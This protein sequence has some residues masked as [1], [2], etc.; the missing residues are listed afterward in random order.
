MQGVALPRQKRAGAPEREETGPVCRKRPPR[1]RWDAAA[2][3]GP[4]RRKRARVLEPAAVPAQNLN[5]MPP[6]A[7]IGA[8]GA[9]KVVVRM[10]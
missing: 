2:E 3:V 9:K 5:R 6:H 10:G 7:P 4:P 8:P 1:Q